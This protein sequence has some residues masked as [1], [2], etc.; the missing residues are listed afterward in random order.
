MP[1]QVDI[2]SVPPIA[3]WEQSGSLVHSF[4]VTLVIGAPCLVSCSPAQRGSGQSYETSVRSRISPHVH[5]AVS[6]PAADET[7]LFSHSDVSHPP[8]NTLGRRPRPLLPYDAAVPPS[9]PSSNSNRRHHTSS[10]TP[11]KSQS[12]SLVFCRTSG[13]PL[14]GCLRATEPFGQAFC[15]IQRVI[16][17]VRRY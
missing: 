12:H 17:V 5:H 1:Q 6:Q 14:A 2:P 8:T 3:L 7:P 15:T 16:A 10:L 9:L 4:H 13:S 11:E